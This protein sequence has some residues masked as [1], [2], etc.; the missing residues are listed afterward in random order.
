MDDRIRRLRS[1]AHQLVRGKVPR[2]IR[3][4]AAFRAA[5]VALAGPRLARGGS[6]ARVARDLG[7]PAQCLGR[8]RHA[9]PAAAPLRPVALVPTAATA[10]RPP[11]G[12]VLLTSHGHRVEGL[13]RDALIAVLRALA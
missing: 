1:E 13:D 3:Y 11:A 10:P 5:A 2:A 12:F 4:P 8:W 7:L 6:I 9:R